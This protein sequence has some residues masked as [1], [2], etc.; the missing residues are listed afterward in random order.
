MNARYCCD[1]PDSLDQAVLDSVRAHRDD[2]IATV[3]FVHAHPELGH[4]EVLCA[5]HLTETLASVGY[6]I[7]P[8]PGI[9]TAFRASLTGT[10]PGKTVGLVVIYDAVATVGSDAEPIPMHS[11]GHGPISGGVVAAAAALA[12]LRDRLA[13]RVVVVGCPAD[14]IHAPRTREIGGGKALTAAAGVW[15]DIDVALY[16]H[17]EFLNTVSLASLWMSRERVKVVGIRSLRQGTPQPPLDAFREAAAVA[18][19]ADPGRVMVERVVL[20]GDVE[21][22]TGL[23]VDATFLLLE[24]T[25]R[26]LD[27]SID[28]LR[29][30]FPSGVWTGGQKVSGVRPNDAVIAIVADAFRAA[31]HD[32]EP[33]PPPLPF[34]TD[35][36]NISH[37]VP[38]A[39]IGVGRE[40][41][42]HFI[43]QRASGSSPVPTATR[44]RSRLLTYSPCRP[45]AS[46]KQSRRSVDAR[47]EPLGIAASFNRC[48]ADRC[49]RL[50][51]FRTGR[52]QREPSVGQP[53]HSPVCRL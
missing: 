39:L 52:H 17:P 33:S 7:A 1:I 3:R 48:R 35:F 5:A 50:I 18:A 21:E 31:G 23:V 28:A 26:E 25:E 29:S 24:E 51:E 30:R 11:C 34:A 15:D 10:R 14:E 20:D 22:G 2:A 46:Q 16:A 27:E 44:L 32:F 19:E 47:F 42:G 8:V 53:T 41:A 37:R 49:A 6:E 40:E 12:D 45:S 36:G 38:A 43:R 13:G 4:E 9:P